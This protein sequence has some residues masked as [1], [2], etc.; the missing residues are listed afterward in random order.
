MTRYVVWDEP[1][2]DFTQPAR[3]V[4]ELDEEDATIL[5][6]QGRRVIPEELYEDRLALVM[7]V[8]VPG[9]DKPMSR[10]TAEFIYDG[11]FHT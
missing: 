10:D 8:Y 11:V 1:N 9:Q 6:L 2:P 3:S 5:L 4:L 7:D